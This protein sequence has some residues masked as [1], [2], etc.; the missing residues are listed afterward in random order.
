MNSQPSV[1]DDYKLDTLQDSYQLAKPSEYMDTK[2]A[3]QVALTKLPDHCDSHLPGRLSELMSVETCVR[4]S[5]LNILRLNLTSNNVCVPISY[6]QD[7]YNS[8]KARPF[9][10]DRN[11]QENFE[12]LGGVEIFAK[13]YIRLKQRSPDVPAEDFPFVTEWNEVH[14]KIATWW[15]IALYFRN[16]LA[17]HQLNSGVA[18]R[19]GNGTGSRARSDEMDLRGTFRKSQP[20]SF[21]SF[22]ALTGKLTSTNPSGATSSTV[23]ARRAS[24]T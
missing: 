21:V 8:N 12:W 1:A 18:G 17:K 16:E 7:G 22:P 13:Q 23:Q 9:M 5:D 3:L 11:S 15:A 19:I 6:H 2:Y 20:S 10:S 4:L 24:R 14:A